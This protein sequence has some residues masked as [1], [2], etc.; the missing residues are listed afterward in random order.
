MRRY[1]K[2]EI[3]STKKGNWYWIDKNILHQY[4]RRLR[5]S[6]IAVY[7]ALASF[8]NSETQT[9]F[10]TQKTMAELIGVSRRTIIRKIKFLKELVLIRVEKKKG[11]CH[12]QLLK[13]KARVTSD[14]QRCDKRYTSDATQG[15]INKNY[16]IKINNKNIDINKFSNPEEFKPRTR[17]QLLAFDIAKEL[18]DLKALRLYLSYVKKYPES[19]LRKILGEVKEIPL[20]KIKKSRGALFNYLVKKYAHKTSKNHRN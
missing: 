5:P 1:K 17:K 4:G 16:L 13:L 15:N 12:Y 14:S 9:C 20:K 3:R 11:R 7:N 2:H 19:L 8:V 18:N 10:P 6:G